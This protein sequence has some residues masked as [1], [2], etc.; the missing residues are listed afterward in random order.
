MKLG[1]GANPE[2]TMKFE[3][4]PNSELFTYGEIAIAFHPCLIDNPE[5]T[6]TVPLYSFTAPEAE[7]KYEGHE[8][9]VPL[10]MLKRVLFKTGVMSHTKKYIKTVSLRSMIFEVIFAVLKPELLIV[11]T[12]YLKGMT[13]FV[14]L[15]LVEVIEKYS[16]E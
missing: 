14:R 2:E 3:N 1:P 6:K 15:V 12:P 4:T 5:A 7:T 9:A 10:Y 16:L 8:P 11:L 13:G